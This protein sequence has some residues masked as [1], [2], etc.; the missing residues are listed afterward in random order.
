[1]LLS[2]SKQ[3]SSSGSH[4]AANSGSYP[5]RPA[6]G[7]SAGSPVAVLPPAPAMSPSVVVASPAFPSS[8]VPVV[9]AAPSLSQAPFQAKPGL[10]VSGPL[11]PVPA[12]VQASGFPQLVQQ[13]PAFGSLSYG[14]PL[15]ASPVPV[16]GA[17]ASPV[18]V[19]GAYASVPVAYVPVGYDTGSSGV[20]AP[21]SEMEGNG[22][23]FLWSRVL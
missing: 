5:R 15:Y 6:S 9:A 8:S 7:S 10:G 13:A 16:G 18:P 14:A 20:G 22:S 4:A 23:E 11:V 3:Q 19:G 1:M 12:A 17:Y 2:G 21:Q